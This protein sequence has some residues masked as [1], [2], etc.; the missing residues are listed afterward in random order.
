MEK[1]DIISPVPA[2]VMAK[3]TANALPVL[4]C[5][6]AIQQLDHV[7]DKSV[8]TV[9]IDPP[10][11]INKAEW[12]TI[13]NYVQWLTDIIKKLEL[14]LR[15]NGSFFVFHNDMEQIA[16]LMVS[17]KANTKLVFR[18][19]IVW[20]KRFEGS[21]KKGFLD[22]YVVK[23]EL[24]NWN[25]MAEYILFYTFDNSHKLLE[26]RKSLKVAQM[27]I[28]QEIKSRTGGLTGW[29]SNLETGRNHPTRDTIVPIKK[30]LGLDFEDIV[31]KFNN[32]KTHHSVWNYDMAKRTKAHITPK[33]V[34]LLENI[35]RHTTDEGDTVLDCFA[36]SGS[37][38]Q[39]CINTNRRCVLIEKNE[40]YCAHIRETLAL[41]EA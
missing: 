12:D 22:G 10:Y 1:N 33:P 27:T 40:A 13:P 25:K 30:H 3:P 2:T 28:S 6:D 9:C 24:H 29:Y 18:Q 5:G 36:G 23:T 32:M 38:G 19:M 4:Y 21:S 20:N 35:L 41:V 31:P 16:E 39:A 11:N 14:K 7:P 26:T 15:D 34:D 8:Q 37:M 17:I